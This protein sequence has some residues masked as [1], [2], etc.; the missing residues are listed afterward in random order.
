MKRVKKTTIYNTKKNDIYSQPQK[1]N[2][3]WVEISHTL[4]NFI[5][6]IQIFSKV[7]NIRG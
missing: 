4:T 5:H 3:I 1:I 7:I 6:P 2:Q